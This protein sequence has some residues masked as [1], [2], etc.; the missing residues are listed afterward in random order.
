MEITDESQEVYLFLCSLSPD[1]HRPDPAIQL[2]FLGDL[3]T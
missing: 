2:N 3:P 1:M